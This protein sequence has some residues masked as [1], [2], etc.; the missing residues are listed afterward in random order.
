[1]SIIKVVK[2]D[3]LQLFRAGCFDEI[4]HGCNCF[5]NMGAG[6]ALQIAEEFPE[7]LVED[8]RTK[9]GDHN[10][11]GQYCVAETDYGWINNMYTQWTPGRVRNPQHLYDAIRRGFSSLDD[12]LQDQASNWRVGIPLIGAGLAGGDWNIIKE[13]INEAAPRLQITVVEFKKHK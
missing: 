5:H 11:L 10:K 13:V 8:K 6:I 1:M 3:L 7:A 9:H 4:V 2:G 12:S